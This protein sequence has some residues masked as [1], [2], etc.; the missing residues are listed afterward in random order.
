MHCI[1]VLKKEVSPT[2]TRASR[3]RHALRGSVKSRDISGGPFVIGVVTREKP[4]RPESLSRSFARLLLR[5]IE[6]CQRLWY[7]RYL[8]TNAGKNIWHGQIEATRSSTDFLRREF[9]NT[10]REDDEGEE[11]YEGKEEEEEERAKEGRSFG[12]VFLLVTRSG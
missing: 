1:I 12:R 9:R 11:E 4:P 7:S 10:G 2:E 3:V 6:S 5:I 8:R